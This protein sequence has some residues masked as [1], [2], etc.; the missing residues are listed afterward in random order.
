[1]ELVVTQNR[2]QLIAAMPLVRKYIAT[3]DSLN[4][5]WSKIT[6]IGKINSHT[7]A[8]T[9]LSELEGTKKKFSNLQHKLIEN[10]ILENLNKEISNSTSKAQ[11]AI[12]IL[13]RNL[14][15]RTADVGFLATDD[16]IRDFLSKESPAI[17]DQE[18][19]QKRLHEYV[20]KYSVY[21]EIVVL[22][23]SGHVKAHLDTK[24]PISICADPLIKETLTSSAAYIETFRHSD[25][26][27]GNRHSLIYSAKITRSNA[28]TSGVIGVLCLCFR[29]DNEMQGI[30]DNLLD[31]QQEMLLMIGDKNGKVIASSNEAEVGVDQACKKFLHPTITKYRGQDYLAHT[32]ST[33]G[34]QGYYGLGWSGQVM[35]PL[36]RMSDS[37][38]ESEGI[39]FD[40]DMA[41]KAKTFSLALK[42]IRHTSKVINDDLSLVVLNGKI[43][44]ARKD[45]KEFMPVLEAIKRIGED[46]ANIFSDSINNLQATMVNSHL[47]DAAFMSALAVDIMDRNL[48]E[49][50]NDC[51]WWAL[52]SVFRRLLAQRKLSDQDKETISSILGYI[53]GLYTVY[54]NL[55]IYDRNKTILAVS[56]PA[57]AALVGTRVADESGASAALQVSD[58]QKYAVSP[59][60]KTNLYD[61]RYTYIYNAAITNIEH[62]SEILGGIG[63]VFDSEPQFESMLKDVLPKDDEGR[64]RDG[65]FGI[66]VERSGRIIA[67]A[68]TQQYEI[69]K[70]NPFMDAEISG[71]QSGNSLS[72][73][74]QVDGREYALGVTVSQGYREYKTTGDYTNDVLAMIFLPF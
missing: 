53:N 17:D 58:S 67:V 4:G 20:K 48:Y 21:D 72:R 39:N 41:D 18:F 24:N 31:D 43:T 12:D 19:I 37:G 22:S 5:W 69:G 3:L 33:N 49:R 10:L 59:F 11:V 30:F 28:D 32:L 42:E 61:G 40:S 57:D 50:A 34:Y 14:F 16:D 66:F 8:A 64:I 9:I 27:P 25:L 56:S 38:R 68:N 2:E 45:A 23:P 46:T 35:S 26:Q 47:S 44:A 63:I 7:V 70:N 62:P 36:N 71:L 15:E 6:M 52:T 1:M 51:R 54:T 74:I 73:I 55:Y 29:F 65:G 13:I 60:T